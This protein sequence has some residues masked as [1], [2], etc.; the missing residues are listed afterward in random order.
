MGRT[1]LSQISFIKKRSKEGDDVI[2]IS[3]VIRTFPSSQTKGL[4]RYCTIT[5]G[6]ISCVRCSRSMRFSRAGF[7]SV[8]GTGSI[9]AILS[10]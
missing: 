8:I 9:L 5:Y 3:N 1:G 2:F 4:R 10:Y 7:S 6:C